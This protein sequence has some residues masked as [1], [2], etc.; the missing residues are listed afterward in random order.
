MK[1]LRRPACC[2]GLCVALVAFGLGAC[3]PAPASTTLPASTSEATVMVL[4]T[5]APVI[6]KAATL[7]PLLASPEGVMMDNLSEEGRQWCDKARQDLLERLKVTTGEITLVRAEEVQW[8]DSSLG[9]PKPGMMY[10]QVIT[11][12]YRIVLEHAGQEF[13][14]HVGNNRMVLCEPEE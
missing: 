2:M 14:Y 13:D 12:G 7:A 3:A 6:T 11:P 5:P 1:A 9:C 10:A 8:S 4:P